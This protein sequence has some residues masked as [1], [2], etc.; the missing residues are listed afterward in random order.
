V[1][2]DI[3][4]AHVGATK[5]PWPSPREAVTVTPPHPRTHTTTE[6]QGWGSVRSTPSFDAQPGLRSLSFLDLGGNYVFQGQHKGQGGQRALYATGHIA[7]FA[8]CC[9]LV[10]G[11]LLKRAGAPG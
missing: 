11:F 2:C 9:C 6:G 8:V 3:H 7:P 4:A 5:K 1:N 10:E